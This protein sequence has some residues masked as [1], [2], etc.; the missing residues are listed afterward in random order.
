MS[1]SLLGPSAVSHCLMILSYE[2]ALLNREDLKPLSSPCVG[3][4]EEQLYFYFVD[5][6]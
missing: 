1:H 5:E 3:S 4:Q 2:V 6:A